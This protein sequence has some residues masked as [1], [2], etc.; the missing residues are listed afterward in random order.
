MDA[1]AKSMPAYTLV[2]AFGASL[3]AYRSLPPAT[4]LRGF[5][6][7]LLPTAALAVWL[8]LRLLA[9]RDRASGNGVF[10]DAYDALLFRIVVC[11]LALHGIILVGLIGLEVVARGHPIFARLTPTLFGLGAIVIGDR[12]P[13]LRPNAA[14]GI[15]TRRTLADRSVWMRVH[16]TAGH[17]AVAFGTAIVAMSLV[18]PLGVF[19]TACM[20]LACAISIAVLTIKTRTHSHA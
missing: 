4:T 11:I 8:L 12:L 1:S 19:L 15:R 20:S 17:V 10:A 16:R 5:I 18:L 6:A 14:L 7:F 13:R 9:S 2:A 3:V